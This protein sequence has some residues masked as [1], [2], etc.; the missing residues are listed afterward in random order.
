M[1][2]TE[3]LPALYGILARHQAGQDRS[4]QKRIGPSEI[5][6]E[7]D[8]ALAYR[9]QGAEKP[10]DEALKWA[11]LVGT[12]IHAGIAEA[13]AEDNER[14]MVAG[15]PARWIVE[16]RVPVSRQLGID[17]VTDL[18]D[19][20]DQEVVDWKAVGK[21]RM[22]HY[23]RHGPG[24]QYR[25]QAHLYGRGWAILGRPVKSV[26]VVFLPR[27]S[28]LLTD[29][30]E[31]SEPYNE[32]IAV[33]ALDRLVRVRRLAESLDLASASQGFNLI[34]ATPGD[35][36]RFCPYRRLGG[37]ADASGCPGD[38]QGSTERATA[39]FAKGLVA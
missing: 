34:R 36:C 35:D 38:A 27:W 17:G 24:E 1:T 8:R 39:S 23:R 31:W 15:Q 18:Y 5:G 9:L 19:A 29:G 30:W 3:K 26:R 28:H 11:P 6:I 13:M 20:E 12:F 22:T 7:C 14:R 4:L 37:P 21:T 33:E 10:N 32:A 25:V 16:H 2:A